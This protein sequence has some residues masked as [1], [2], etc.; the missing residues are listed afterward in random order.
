MCIQCPCWAVG[1]AYAVACLGSPGTGSRSPANQFHQEAVQTT[2]E[3]A[4][5]AGRDSGQGLR[6]VGQNTAQEMREQV[7]RPGQPNT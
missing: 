1:P 4:Q 6:E 5:S 2:K 7:G 3:Q